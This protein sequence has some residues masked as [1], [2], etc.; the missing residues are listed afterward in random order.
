[1][2]VRDRQLVQRLKARPFALVSVTND[3]E[4]ATLRTAIES[5]EIT[6]RCLW[7]GGRDGPISLRWG[8]NQWP[9]I[10]VL[11]SK[12][13]IRFRNLRDEALNEAVELLL[14][15]CEAVRNLAE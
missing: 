11:D 10:Y 15:E 9:T 14:G 3:A 2:Y 13:I 4:K 1:M 6:R 8:I 5:G 7:D 12:G